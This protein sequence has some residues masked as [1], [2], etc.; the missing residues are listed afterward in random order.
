MNEY[1]ITEPADRVQPDCNGVIPFFTAFYYCPYFSKWYF[2][3][4]SCLQYSSS[5]LP[6]TRTISS[7]KLSSMARKNNRGPACPL[8]TDTAYVL[9]L[10]SLTLSCCQNNRCCMCLHTVPPLSFSQL[11]VRN[12]IQIIS[13][14]GSF[15][16][17]IISCYAYHCCIICTEY[18]RRM[19]ELYP[20]F[21]TF[22]FKSRSER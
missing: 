7:M 10:H 13:T 22:L 21:C 17:F 2:S 8:L 14:A 11:Q 15:D 1:I 3:M 19:I 5:P 9:C 20:A 4:I 6:T 18:R 12:C 16:I